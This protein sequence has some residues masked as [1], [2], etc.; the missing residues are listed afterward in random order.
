[1]P[2]SA[3]RCDS[4]SWRDEQPG[5]CPGLGSSI[6]EGFLIIATGVLGFGIGSRGAAAAE[7]TGNFDLE[8]DDNAIRQCRAGDVPHRLQDSDKGTEKKKRVG[9]RV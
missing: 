1:M 3:E 8:R 9:V 6:G 7:K 5:P 4:S 2:C